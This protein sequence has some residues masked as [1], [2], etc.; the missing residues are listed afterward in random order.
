MK[1]QKSGD[2][3]IRRPMRVGGFKVAKNQAVDVVDS[4]I[5]Y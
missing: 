2:L 4:G 5:D 3:Y 1:V